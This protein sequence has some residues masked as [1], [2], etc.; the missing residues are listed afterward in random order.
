MNEGF[1]FLYYLINETAYESNLIIK[2]GE[3]IIS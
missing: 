1:M 3:I 2:L